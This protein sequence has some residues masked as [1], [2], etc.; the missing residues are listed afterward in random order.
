MDV[1]L[2]GAIAA[3]AIIVIL[4]LI[5]LFSRIVVVP[6]NLTGLISGSNRGTVKIIHPGGRDFVLPVIQS[7]Q[8]LPFTQTTISFK[9]TAEDENKINVNVAAVAAVK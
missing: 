9:V 2:I 6:S 4:V 1:T 8:Y 5:Y 3:I 7:I